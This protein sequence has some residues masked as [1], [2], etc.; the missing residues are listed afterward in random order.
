MAA[1]RREPMTRRFG[2]RLREGRRARGLSQEQLAA[3]TT[4]HR[5]HVSLIE[6]AKREPSLETLVLLSRGLGISPAEMILWHEPRG[7]RAQPRCAF[8][9]G[10]SSANA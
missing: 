6:R 4:L 1:A 8:D 7:R 2:E 3:N 10:S 5:T 9:P